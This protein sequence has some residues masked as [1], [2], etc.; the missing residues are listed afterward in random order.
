ML[1]KMI[2]FVDT[3]PIGRIFELGEKKMAWK[4]VTELKTGMKIAVANSSDYSHERPKRVEWDEI[5]SIKKVGRERV[6]DIEV[7]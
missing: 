7:E 1:N 2:N 6:Y 5:V 3:H 4:R